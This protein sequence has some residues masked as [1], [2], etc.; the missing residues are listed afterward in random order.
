MILF[1]YKILTGLVLATSI[2]V[3]AAFL[4]LVFF[5]YVVIFFKL[6]QNKD[7]YWI[8]EYSIYIMWVVWI[9][10]FSYFLYRSPTL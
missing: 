5:Y 1:L 2:S 3:L 4:S 8:F 7:A 6:N 10:S 9:L